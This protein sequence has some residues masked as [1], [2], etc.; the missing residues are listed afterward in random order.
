M[1]HTFPADATR[2]AVLEALLSNAQIDIREKAELPHARSLALRLGDG[3]NITILLD[4]GFGAWR[5]GGAP[6]HDFSAKPAQQA[7]SL[8]SLN[9]T[10][11]V[12]SGC[13]APIVLE[14]C[15]ES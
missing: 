1:F 10:I 5:T 11:G 6:K 8:K 14:E 4:Q 12:E 15:Q 13:Q 3:R 9:F 2:G 7:R